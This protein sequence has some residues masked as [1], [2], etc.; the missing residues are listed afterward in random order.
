MAKNPPWLRALRASLSPLSHRVLQRRS[1]GSAT[2]PRHNRQR[3]MR[4]GPANCDSPKIPGKARLLLLSSAGS[5]ARKR[6]RALQLTIVIVSLLAVA[7]GIGA[8][9]GFTG[10]EKAKAES[11]RA[12]AESARTKQ[13]LSKSDF[14]VNRTSRIPTI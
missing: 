9:F 5:A 11:R 14:R 7:A 3:R 4:E 2:L 13:A 1:R 12:E 8:Y 10:E 6:V